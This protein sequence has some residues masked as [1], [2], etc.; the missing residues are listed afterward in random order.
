V[1]WPP[2]VWLGAKFFFEVAEMGGKA[3]LGDLGV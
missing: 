2:P 3:D 1:R